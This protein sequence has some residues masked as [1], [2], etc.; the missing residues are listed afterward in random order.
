VWLYHGGS[1]R[2]DGKRGQQEVGQ[3]LAGLKVAVADVGNGDFG[4]RLVTA[5][6][7]E[8]PALP[9]ETF[10]LTLAAAEALGP[11]EGTPRAFELAQADLIVGPWTMAAPLAVGA[12]PGAAEAVAMS[13][14]RKLL[15]P[16]AVD[17]WQWTGG[18]SAD[19]DAHA[20]QT[21]RAV[22]Q[23][24]QGEAVQGPR[25]LSAAA[26]VAI[27][28]GAIVALILIVS[29]LFWFAFARGF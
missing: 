16:V 1:V 18:D 23:V 24:V 8:L 7:R 17:G 3:R 29:V 26:I 28:I 19:L 25:P 11:A 12:A 13:P 27:V 20:L 14:A 5:L 4:R 21:A 6:K 2:A 15:S 9:V 22:R 10:G